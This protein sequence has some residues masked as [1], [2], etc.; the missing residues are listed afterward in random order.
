MDALLLESLSIVYTSR[1]MASAGIGIA[2]RPAQ[3][4]VRCLVHIQEV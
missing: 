4:D 1:M 2:R 3:G